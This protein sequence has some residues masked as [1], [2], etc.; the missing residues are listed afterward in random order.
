M[1]EETSKGW[2]VFIQQGR[3]YMKTAVGGIKRRSVFTND[4]LYNIVAMAIE[5]YFMGFFQYHGQMPENHTLSD[6]VQGVEK[7]T[8]LDRGL[9]EGL[10]NMDRFQEICAWDTYRRQKPNE[11]DIEAFLKLGM[12]VEKFVFENVAAAKER[13][14]G[15][16]N[17]AC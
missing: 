17:P 5:K 16:W 2:E 8:L 15:T 3:Q 9:S 4:L 7:I 13:N 12:D 10:L 6:L 11:E 1:A 14:K